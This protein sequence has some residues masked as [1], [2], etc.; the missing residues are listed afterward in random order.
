MSQ[1]WYGSLQ[2]RLEE[3]PDLRDEIENKVREDIGLPTIGDDGAVSAP[4]ADEQ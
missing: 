1:R 3:N 4:A 2:N